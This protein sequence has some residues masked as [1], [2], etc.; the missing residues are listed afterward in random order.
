[1]IARAAFNIQFHFIEKRININFSYA[2]TQYIGQLASSP[3]GPL[4]LNNLV[5]ALG[6]D[7]HV[8]TCIGK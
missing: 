5:V 6:S 3:S 2:Q 7:L 8:R 4:H 1:M